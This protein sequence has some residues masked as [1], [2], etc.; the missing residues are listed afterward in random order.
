MGQLNYEGKQA[1][2]QA[3]S[4]RNKNKWTDE[5][6]ENHVRL[7]LSCIFVNKKGQNTLDGL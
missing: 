3:I 4:M 1:I 2:R 7:V 5:R 6:N